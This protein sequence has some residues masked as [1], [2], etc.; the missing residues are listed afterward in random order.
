LGLGGANFGLELPYMVTR[1]GRP[2]L[3]RISKENIPRRL[4]HDVD[5]AFLKD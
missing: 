5:A 2:S 1:W 3:K 4:L